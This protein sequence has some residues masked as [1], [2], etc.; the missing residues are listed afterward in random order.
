MTA[1]VGWHTALSLI[2]YIYTPD[3][4]PIYTLCHPGVGGMSPLTTPYAIYHLNLWHTT[5]L[6]MAYI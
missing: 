6:C 3:I 5:I 4:I 1:C 2:A